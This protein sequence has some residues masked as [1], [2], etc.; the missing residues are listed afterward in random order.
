M[1]LLYHGI[2]PDNSPAERLC[3]GQALPL[4]VLER[5]FHW[6]A[7]KHRIVSLPIYLEGMQHKDFLKDKPLTISFD[8][9]FAA[10]F[11]CVF[12]LLVEMNIPATIFITTGHLGHGDLL[13]FSY[14]K[15]L[16][17][18]NLYLS[19]SVNRRTFPLQTIT[20]RIHAW[21]ELRAMAKLSEQPSNF[22]KMLAVNYP[23]TSE[24]KAL[25]T[26]MTFEQLKT[27][28][29]SN[30]LE[31]GAHTITHPYL[32]QLTR[33]EQEQEILGSRDVLSKL[34]GKPIRYFAYPGGDYNHDTLKL[35]QASG[36]EASF[37]TI[38]KKM[39]TNHKLE[40]DRIGIYSQ[41]LLKLQIKTFGLA[42]WARK[43]GVRI[44]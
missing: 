25:Y 3:A 42:D 10:T 36:Y 7:K 40:I 11:Q 8:D 37:A 15:A 1:I 27:A 32:D 18:E 24:I 20:Q 22:S 35:L 43:V 28:A 34:T 13:W 30:I 29:G 23:L 16:C 38:S 39:G 5:H 21:N 33:Q 12:P 6:L 14:L 26:G 2:V 19:V 41:S 17:F 4:A 31:L 9:G 44:G